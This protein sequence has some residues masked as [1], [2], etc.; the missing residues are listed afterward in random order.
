M[1]HEIENDVDVEGTRR[2][3]A[4]SMRLEEHWVGEGCEGGGDGRIEALEVTDGDNAALCL[5]ERKDVV[6]LSE[7]CGERLLDE[8]VEAG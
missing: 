8:D 2:E 6:R 1:D 3:D 5:G 7:G 4:E